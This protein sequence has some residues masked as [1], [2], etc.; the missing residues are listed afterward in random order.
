MNSLYTAALGQA[1]LKV[2]SWPPASYSI[3]GNLCMHKDKHE[4]VVY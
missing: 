4:H 3:N 2:T 1:R